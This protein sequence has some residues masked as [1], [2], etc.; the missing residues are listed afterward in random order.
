VT[1]LP[2]DAG[3]RECLFTRLLLS[4]SSKSAARVAALSGDGMFPAVAFEVSPSHESHARQAP[5]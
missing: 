1:R 2:F 3:N 5:P 4:S